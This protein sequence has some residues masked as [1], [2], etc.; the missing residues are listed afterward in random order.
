[1]IFVI[2][3]RRLQF[4]FVLRKKNKQISVLHVVHHGVVPFSVWFGVRFVPGGH[5]TFFGMLNSFVHIWMYLYYGLAAM[6][7]HIQKYLWW[8][9]YL[10]KLQMVQFVAFSCHT[11]QLLFIECNFPKAF[12]WLIGS[13]GVVFFFLFMNFYQH[14][15]R[16]SE[17]KPTRALNTEDTATALGVVAREKMEAHE[18]KKAWDVRSSA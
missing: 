12:V 17:S 4:F 18:R 14:S 16:S 15:Y 2:S 8:K 11:F 6:G 13:H 9:K 3:F 5:A 10:T 7:P 1:M